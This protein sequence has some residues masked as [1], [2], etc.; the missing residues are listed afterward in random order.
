MGTPNDLCWS[1]RCISVYTDAWHY[2][3]FR[4]ENS[5]ISKELLSEAL[6]KNITHIQESINESEICYMVNGETKGT[7]LNN[8]YL[9]HKCKEWAY[10][11][12]RQLF[13][14]MTCEEYGTKGYCEIANLNRL[15][16]DN[17]C[18]FYAETEPEAIF[19]ACEWIL[20]ESK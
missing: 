15:N 20:K 8:H 13:S 12:N 4:K 18:D 1:N 14:G 7:F 5:M 9:A 6:E 11:N 3:D 16:E 10:K 2:V 17:E 19:K